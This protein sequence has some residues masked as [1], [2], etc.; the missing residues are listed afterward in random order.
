M[1]VFITGD[2]VRMRF[3]PVRNYLVSQKEK[4]KA[5]WREI[6][7]ILGKEKNVYESPAEN[8]AILQADNYLRD[9]DHKI[10]EA[11]QSLGE[12][13]Y[14]KNK[15]TD[16]TEFAEE[17][18]NITE[19]QSKAH[20]LRQY[21]LNL[22]GKVRCE[23]CNAIVT[24]ESLFCNMCGKEIIKYDFSSL[25]VNAVASAQKGNEIAHCPNCGEEVIPG[26]KF[27]EKCGYRI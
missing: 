13:Y 16:S 6:M 25:G 5:K 1:T 9:T 21:R 3:R 2:T 19:L 12:A 11:F 4:Q 15:G 23:N 8:Q 7:A 20:L 26:A 27:C 14:E 18:K 17:L 22:E 10:S 24:S